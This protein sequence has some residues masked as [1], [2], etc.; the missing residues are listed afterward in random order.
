MAKFGIALFGNI[1]ITYTSEAYPTEA[2]TLGMFITM[3]AS[4]IGTI[5]MPFL[6]NVFQVRQLNPLFLFGVLGIFA[7]IAIYWLQETHGRMREQ[8]KDSERPLLS[9]NMTRRSG[10]ERFEDE[11]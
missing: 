11:D 2:R 9:F 5:A 7:S 1:L 3:Q 6:I 4:R 10:G 8:L